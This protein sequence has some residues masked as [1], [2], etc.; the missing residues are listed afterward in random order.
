MKIEHKEY[1][2]FYHDLFPA[3]YCQHLTNEFNRLEEAGIGSNRQNSERAHKH[4]KDDYQIGINLR[5]H[6][7]EPFKWTETHDDGVERQFEKMLAIYFLMAC[8]GAMTITP[9]SIQ[10][11]ETMATSGLR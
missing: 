10:S 11:F 4:I 8:N 6:S 7:L 9:A 2:G 1:V 3:G 5:N